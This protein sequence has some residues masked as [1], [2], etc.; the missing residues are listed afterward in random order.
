MPEIGDAVTYPTIYSENYIVID[1][2]QLYRC[3]AIV[4]TLSNE[5]TFTKE[6]KYILKSYDTY[7]A[8]INK[9]SFNRYGDNKTITTYSLDMLCGLYMSHTTVQH[10]H[11]FCRLYGNFNVSIPDIRKKME[12]SRTQ[13]VKV[14]HHM[15][16]IEYR[17]ANVEC[18]YYDYSVN[19]RFKIYTRQIL[20]YDVDI[21]YF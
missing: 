8:A 11:K 7:V 2:K 21:H 10:F 3:K 18:T 16:C 17:Y 13:Y 14:N 6:F 19:H 12:N 5:G 9:R 20:N 15:P 1:K 4:Y